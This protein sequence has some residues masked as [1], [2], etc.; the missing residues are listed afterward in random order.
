MPVHEH[1]VCVCVCVLCTFACKETTC[2][3][4]IITAEQLHGSKRATTL[5]YDALL[6]TFVV[7][8]EQLAL[9]SFAYVM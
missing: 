6:H 8:V 3:G 5:I 9:Q 7:F 1:Y 2:R 4:K